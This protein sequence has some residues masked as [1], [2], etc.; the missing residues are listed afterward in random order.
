MKKIILN[1]LKKS[2]NEREMKNVTGGYEPVCPS[3]NPWPI[4]CANG[5]L[6]CMPKKDDTC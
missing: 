5:N 1:E 4:R 6:K 3:D 2:L